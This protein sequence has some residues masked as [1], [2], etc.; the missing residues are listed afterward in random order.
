MSLEAGDSIP[1]RPP[2]RRWHLVVGFAALAAFLARGQ[3]MDLAHDHLRGLEEATRLLFRS[4]HI[5][6]LFS[7][8]LNVVLG[9]YQ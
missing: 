2:T 5:Y 4:T 8:L 6:L 9:L 7:A 1:A 3:Y